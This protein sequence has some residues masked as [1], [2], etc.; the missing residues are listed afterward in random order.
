MLDTDS[1]HA[2]CQSKARMDYERDYETEEDLN[3]KF[4]QFVLNFK[5]AYEGKNDRRVQ[6]NKKVIKGGKYYYSAC[7]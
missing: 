5:Q 2:I 6:I 4:K 1:E 7:Y 3:K